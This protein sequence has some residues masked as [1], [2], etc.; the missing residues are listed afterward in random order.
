MGIETQS[1]SSYR[2]AWSITSG[3][4]LPGVKDLKPPRLFLTPR[5]K[6]N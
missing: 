4:G 6:D 5:P 2:L 3:N 1:G